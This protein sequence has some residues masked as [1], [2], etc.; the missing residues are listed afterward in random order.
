[1]Q[2][3][4]KLCKHPNIFRRKKEKISRAHARITYCIKDIVCIYILYSIIVFKNFLCKLLID[5]YL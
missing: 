3:Y 5:R 4:N 2:K 1:M